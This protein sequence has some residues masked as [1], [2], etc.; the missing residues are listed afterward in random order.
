MDRFLLLVSISSLLFT[1]CEVKEDP[2]LIKQLEETNSQIEAAEIELENVEA[3]IK[4][5]RITDPSEELTKV[6]VGLEGAAA[7]KAA[8]EQEI[9]ELGEAQKKAAAELSAY[10]EKY[11]L[12]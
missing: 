4:E 12:R 2:E 11:R 1:A 6:K 7:R 3:E 5:I 9:L 8:L 10:K